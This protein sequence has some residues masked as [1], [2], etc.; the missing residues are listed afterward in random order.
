MFSI[1][2]FSTIPMGDDGAGPRT[3]SVPVVYF[4]NKTLAFPLKINKVAEFDLN[5]NN[6]L[7]LSLKRNTIL[8]FTV[9]R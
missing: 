5:L 4:M 1:E 3:G 7:D 2:P 9:R 6:I 8:E